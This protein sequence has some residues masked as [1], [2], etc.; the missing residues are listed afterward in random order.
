MR[1]DRVV[2]DPAEGLTPDGMIRTGASRTRV[3]AAFEP[4][5]A[6]AIEAFDQLQARSAELHLYGS[7]ATGMAR[8]NKSD[9]DLLL[10]GGSECWA[11]DLSARLTARFTDVCRGVEIGPAPRSAYFGD[12]DKAYGNRVFLRHYC[13]P[14]AA[15][16]RYAR[17]PRFPATCVL[18][19]GSTGTSGFT[20]RGG[21]RAPSR[22]KSLGRRWLPR[23]AWSASAGIYGPQI[24]RSP[25]AG[26]STSS[27]SGAASW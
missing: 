4:V 22:G 2:R 20:L 27:R 7:V 13:V 17:R 21:G 1:D 3:A 14:L 15:Q 9:V 12:G 23:P 10:V 11:R 16:M 6:A 18:P 5:L 8:V 24:V 25:P 19:G 26:G